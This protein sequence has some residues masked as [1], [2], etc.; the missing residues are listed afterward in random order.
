[1][2]L[3]ISKI[4]AKAAILFYLINQLF[5]KISKSLDPWSGIK[6]SKD[7]RKHLLKSIELKNKYSNVK[8]CF[9]L[10]CGPSINTQDLKKLQGEF[11]ISVSSF[12]VHPDFKV[13]NPAFHVF[14]PSEPHMTPDYI[15]NFFSD[16]EK[17]STGDTTA[18]VSITDKDSVCKYN[19]LKKS[20]YYFYKTINR[21]PK[22][23]EYNFELSKPIPFVQTVAHMAIYLAINL[24]IKEIYLLGVD[25]DMIKNLGTISH[26]YKEEQTEFTK[27]GYKDWTNDIDL[28]ALGGHYYNMWIIYK[29]LKIY[30]D[31]NG[32]SIVNATPNSLLDV[33][34]RV[35]FNSLF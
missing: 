17:A 34:P 35:N 11:C 1:M 3:V 28:E 33:F 6:I 8:R 30:S 24:G 9:I 18:I 7:D 14:A 29:Q 20:K 5:N 10:A 32:I 23:L 12:Y 15:G 4:F 27:D 2:K 26:F 21:L 13:I 25:H 31:N 19:G 16:F 22:D